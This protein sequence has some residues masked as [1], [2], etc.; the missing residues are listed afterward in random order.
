MTLNNVVVGMRA[1]SKASGIEATEIG[2]LTMNGGGVFME[3]G[4]EGAAIASR[5]VPLTLNG[6]S[7]V[8]APGAKGEGIIGSA[9]PQT[10]TNTTIQMST[11]A[12]GYG[13]A[14]ELGSLAMNNVS[15]TDEGASSSAAA[16]GLF[17]AQ[18]ANINGVTIAMTNPASSASAIRQT[19][20][21]TNFEHLTVGGSWTGPSFLAEGGSTTIADSRLIEAPGST[22]FALGYSGTSDALGV[23][24][25]RSVLQ[26]APTAIPGT[27][28][29][30]AANIAIDSS[31]VLGGTKGVFLQHGGG[32]RRSLTLVGSTIDAGNLG[33]ADG[34]GV[35]DVEL[36]VGGTASTLTASI[37]GSILLE[38]Q[39][40]GMA[41]GSHASIQCSYSDV[42]SQSQAETATEGSI[43]CASGAAGNTSSAAAALFAAPISAYQLNPTSSALDSV[44]ADAITL[45]FGLVP[46]T[47]D[48]AGNP[49]T[50]DGNG[51]CLAVQDRGAL[52]LQGHAAACP[53]SPLP[54]VVPAKAI[55]GVISGLAISPRAFFAAPSGATISANAA[56]AK[57]RYGAKVSYR[58]SQAAKTN[59]TVVRET[60]G[61]RQGRSCRKPSRSN[62]HAKRC[63]LV[64]ILGSF[65][66]TDTV[67]TNSLHF[68]GR[69]NGRK[70][71]PGAYVLRAIAHNAA[72]NG[73]TVSAAFTIK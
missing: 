19:L 11:S 5:L 15:I 20:G 63:K 72:G 21:T 40:A 53:P 61:R 60:S 10:I 7:I 26:A 17:L 39:K 70:L 18:P 3:S 9:A 41:A 4:S 38:S 66:H 56:R 64:T 28:V 22:T 31:E 48:L 27:L 12:T 65:T 49:R 44:P 33:V 71:T 73:K 47:T 30:V 23:L 6:I 34:A 55:A 54:P 59:F 37:E 25:Q 51:D 68:S 36:G 8:L 16:I 50:F 14:T 2:P 62:G 45:P 1:A 58:D 43:A 69:I 42:P 57:R 46:S 35:T 67:G 24:V 52:E 13:V 29:G 32:K